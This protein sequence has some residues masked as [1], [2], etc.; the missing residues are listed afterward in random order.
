MD[1]YV[2]TVTNRDGV[3]VNEG[4]AD[5]LS[6]V[7]FMAEELASPSDTVSIYEGA[8]DALGLVSKSLLVME[9]TQDGH[10][11]YDRA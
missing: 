6:G 7:V 10:K 1:G 11:N 9:F 3:E 4:Y 8:S 2:I 5:T